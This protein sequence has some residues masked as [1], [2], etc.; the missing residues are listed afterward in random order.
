VFAYLVQGVGY[1]F[2]AAVQPGPFQAFVLSQTMRRGWRRALPIAL[3]P[4][5][6]DGPIILLM[7]LVMRHMPDWLQHALYVAGGMLL[8]YLAWGTFQSWRRFSPTILHEPAPGT[9]SVFE[10]ALINALSPGP[11]LYWSLVT[12]PILAAGW[13]Q[14]PAYGIGFLAGFYVTMIG[15]LAGQIVLFDTARRLGE[16]VNRILI[17]LS[18]LALAGFGLYQLWRGLSGIA[19]G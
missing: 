18:A 17:G 7:L 10:A 3:A 11:Y 2:S 12:G 15:G 6:S 19:S 4:L 5:V 16:R 8:L 1:G 14:A 13:R 9:G